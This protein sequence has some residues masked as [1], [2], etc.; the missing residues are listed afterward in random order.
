M[1]NLVL[2]DFVR[3]PHALFFLEL[4]QDKQFQEQMSSPQCAQHVASIQVLFTD[5]CVVESI[6]RSF[7]VRLTHHQAFIILRFHSLID[8]MKITIV[9]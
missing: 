6:D 4:I 1:V 7:K 5:V 9:D 8:S 2:L 3:F